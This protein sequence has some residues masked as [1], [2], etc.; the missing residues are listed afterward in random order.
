M[1]LDYI[2]DDQSANLGIRDHLETV[3]AI[4]IILV[5]SQTNKLSKHA[6]PLEE[7]LLYTYY[8]VLKPY[9]GDTCLRKDSIT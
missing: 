8:T 3:W 9:I 4:I 6:S 1:M 7:R 5:N 2:S